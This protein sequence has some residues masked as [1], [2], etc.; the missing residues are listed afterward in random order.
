M[1]KPYL[2]A[3]V[4]ILLLIAPILLINV[5]NP[6]KKMIQA[7]PSPVSLPQD[8]QT[9]TYQVYKYSLSFP[10]GFIVEENGEHSRLVK[11]DI[12]PQGL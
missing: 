8:W 11:K 9:Y 4:L 10:S 12:K 5:S 1:R 3:G 7:S 6:Q 2:F